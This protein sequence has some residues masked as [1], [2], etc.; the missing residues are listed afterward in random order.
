MAAAAAVLAWAALLVIAAVRGPL[1]T[2]AIKVGA[3][4]ALPGWLFL[5]VTLAFPAIL[6]GAAAVVGSLVHLNHE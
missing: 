3:V 5:L 6:A 4:L 1:W 2:L